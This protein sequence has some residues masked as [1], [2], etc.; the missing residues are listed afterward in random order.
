MADS[1][2][3]AQ[4]SLKPGTSCDII[5]HKDWINE[6]AD[7]RRAVVYDIEGNTII[8]SQT[9]PPLG[10]RFLRKPMKITFLDK[11]KN[12]PVR[13]GLEASFAKIL[14]DYKLYSTRAVRAVV[15]TAQNIS[16]I[17]PNYDLRM[18]FRV[19]P[20][21]DC[22]IRVLINK[23]EVTIIDFSVGG[24]CFSHAFDHYSKV[25]QIVTVDFYIDGEWQEDLSAKI[26]RKFSNPNAKRDD[27]EY[28]AVQFM[29]PDKKL[30]HL[31]NKEALEIQRRQLS[32]GR[33]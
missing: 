32:Q 13:F 33:L 23:R 11:G 2:I 25:G 6:R 7:I 24:L 27:I 28:T 29:S 1:I 30:G 4:P 20:D 17:N 10:T 26:I 12:G 3:K 19:K 21:A 16:E 9:N 5:V 18:F 22:G 8:L 31:L 14:R 15:M